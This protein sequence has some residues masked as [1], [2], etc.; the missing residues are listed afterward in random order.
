MLF[1]GSIFISDMLKNKLVDIFVGIG[2][3]VKLFGGN[4][5]FYKNSIVIKM[6]GIFFIVNFK[7]YVMINFISLNGMLYFGN[8]KF[9]IELGKY[10]C[11]INVDIF[12]EDYL[13]G[14]VFYEMLVSW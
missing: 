6:F 5:V 11:L 2:F 10:V 9:M 14:V 13:K 12:F 3:I 4:L 1:G 7:K 8:M